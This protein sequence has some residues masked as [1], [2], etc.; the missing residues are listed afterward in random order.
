[1]GA[2][3]H[4]FLR[5]LCSTDFAHHVEHVRSIVPGVADIGLD[6]DR[7]AQ[8]HRAR[9]ASVVLRLDG[10][11]RQLPC[12]I[13]HASAAKHVDD[14]MSLVGREHA[15]RAFLK[16][17]Q[18]AV[19]GLRRIGVGPGRSGR[20]AILR[21]PCRVLESVQF[22]MCQ[23]LG[24]RV[25]LGAHVDRRLA[26]HP[27]AAQ[28]AQILAAKLGLV[29]LR[30][31]HA[32]AAHQTIRARRPADGHA[33]D[34]EGIGRRGVEIEF[35][36]RPAAR[37]TVVRARRVRR[38]RLQGRPCQPP[39]FQLLDHPLAR[40]LD[41][42][43]TRQARPQHVHHVAGRLHDLGGVLRQSQ[44]TDRSQRPI[45]RRRQFCIRGQEMGRERRCRTRH[46]E[47]STIHQL[48]LRGAW[49]VDVRGPFPSRRL[50][51]R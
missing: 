23:A 12:R 17:E 10:D 4:H 8:H 6:Y 41:A 20:R 26:H 48:V 14:A 21:R 9:D 42:G 25:P 15:Q 45:V 1:M 11:A 34:R 22:A 5:E 7:L 38:P 40:L 35:L 19:V 44:I 49:S 2:E 3:H 29:G 28:L 47:R 32:F 30:D 18:V 16:E 27:F 24:H 51:S 31:H 43:R 36:V 13:V 46:H 39:A 37:E 50:S 33:T